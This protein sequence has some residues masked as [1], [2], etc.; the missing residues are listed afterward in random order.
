MSDVATAENLAAL[1]TIPYWC[2]TIISMVY[3]T[4]LP[5]D[6]PRTMFALVLLPPHR[7]PSERRTGPGCPCSESCR[8][9]Q[10]TMAE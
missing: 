5:T 2:E 6:L 8:P 9:W 3:A 4:L 1:V 7:E 10:L